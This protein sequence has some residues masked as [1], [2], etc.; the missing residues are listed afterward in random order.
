M[1]EG[2][3]ETGFFDLH[4]GLWHEHL[5]FCCSLIS[6]LVLWVV[7]KRAKKNLAVGGG[8]SHCIVSFDVSEVLA[9]LLSTRIETMHYY[10]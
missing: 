10:S 9:T 4:G 3:A 1:V 8:S 2:E 5:H 6:S 7:F